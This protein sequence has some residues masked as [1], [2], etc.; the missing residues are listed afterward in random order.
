M[1]RGARLKIEPAIYL[2]RK[3]KLAGA[4]K[5]KVKINFKLKT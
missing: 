3:F 2:E 1:Q 5:A 4:F